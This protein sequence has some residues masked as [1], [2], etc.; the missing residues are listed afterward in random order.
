VEDQLSNRARPGNITG[1]IER[2]GML[3]EPALPETGLVGVIGQKICESDTWV[4]RGMAFQ[5]KA[6]VE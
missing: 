4:H 2:G 5:G 6:S 1:E 3:R